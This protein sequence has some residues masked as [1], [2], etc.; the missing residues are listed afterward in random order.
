[1]PASN[2]LRTQLINEVLRNTNYVPPA[3]VFVGLHTND[4]TAAGTG[5]EV[6]GAWYARQ[7]VTFGAQA[8]PG[9]AENSAAVTFPAVTGASV[10]INHFSIW[11]AATGGNMLYFAPL[12]ASKTF[13]VGDIPSFAAGQIDVVAS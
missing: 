12:T 9:V 13:A 6:T 3:A 7:G 2:F 4:P 8:T 5:A 11:D 1:M 10:T